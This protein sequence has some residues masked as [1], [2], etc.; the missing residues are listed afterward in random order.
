MK[1]GFLSC[2]L[3]RNPPWPFSLSD[4]GKSWFLRSAWV[5]SPLEFWAFDEPPPKVWTFAPTSDVVVLEV[6]VQKASD[7]EGTKN[8][9]TKF[10]TPCNRKPA[11]DDWNSR[12]IL[13]LQVMKTRAPTCPSSCSVF[14][15]N[16]NAPKICNLKYWPA[17]QSTETFSSPRSFYAYG[18]KNDVI[19]KEEWALIC[20][21]LKALRQA[22]A[23]ISLT[24]YISPA[25][26]GTAFFSAAVLPKFAWNALILLVFSAFPFC[27][28]SH[29]VF[30]LHFS[31]ATG[32][33]LEGGRGRE[34]VFNTPSSVI[35]A[36]SH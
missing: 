18:C 29:D 31:A 9:V 34:E 21:N 26:L 22:F 11:P 35:H 6:H 10:S 17:L 12:G 33:F 7:R 13:Q 1:I 25:S 16:F 14:C 5:C 20:I 32:F 23:R 3:S 28:I 15:R 27:P 2:Y 8:R 19:Q 30:S 4:L 36:V 24:N